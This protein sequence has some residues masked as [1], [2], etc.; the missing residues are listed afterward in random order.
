M[1]R[2]EFI[3]SALTVASFGPCI[4]SAPKKQMSHEDIYAIVEKRKDAV[5]KSLI[6]DMEELHAKAPVG[7]YNG[8]PIFC[9]ESLDEPDNYIIVAWNKNQTSIMKQIFEPHPVYEWLESNYEV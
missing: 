6:K 4:L 7:Y 1:N 2:R 9:D 5:I 8:A 3:K